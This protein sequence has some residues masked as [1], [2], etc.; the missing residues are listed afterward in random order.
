MQTLRNSLHDLLCKNRDQFHPV[1]K[2]DAALEKIIALNFTEKNEA[3]KQI[4]LHN[5]Q[6]FSDYITD[7]LTSNHATFGFG[8]YDEIRVLYKR[9]SLFDE[10]DTEEPR[11]LHLGIDIWGNEG[12]EVF[13]PLDGVVHSYAFNNNYGDY[14]AT[15]ILSHCIDGFEFFT[16]YGHLSLADIQN[17]KEGQQIKHGQKFSHFGQPAENGQWPP[18]LHF[19]I[20]KNLSGYHG[21]YPGVCKLSERES[22]LANCP[23]P[24]I[25][26]NLGSFVS[27]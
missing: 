12:T 1:V 23:D 13:A 10:G 20:I 2:F 4:D 5:I 22:Y 24:D 11:R 27:G 15:I 16:L 7:E 25:I 14:G 8:G 6:Q 17:L 3:L 9:S 19:Q 26:L 18:H 21:D